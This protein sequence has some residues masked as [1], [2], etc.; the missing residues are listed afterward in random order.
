MS[1]RSASTAASTKHAA[2]VEQQGRGAVGGLAQLPREGAVLGQHRGEPLLDGRRGWRRRRERV[3]DGRELE[4]SSGAAARTSILPP[5]PRLARAGRGGGLELA[6]AMAR[7]APLLFPPP[8]LSLSPPPRQRWLRWRRRKTEQV[9]A[10]SSERR[11]GGPPVCE[12]KRE[13]RVADVAIGATW[14]SDVAENRGGFGLGVYFAR[15][16]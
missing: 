4:L 8:S 13:E 10:A 5:L 7:A 3:D 11:G 2:V 12:R 6:E 15:F 16:R 1:T 9:T 14:T